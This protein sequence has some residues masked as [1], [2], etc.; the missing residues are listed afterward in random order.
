MAQEM[1]SDLR[2][3]RRCLLFDG[4][5]EAEL[6]SLAGL[7][8]E[9][10]FAPGTAIV[11]ENEPAN[12]I[13]IICDGLVDVV[14]R[15]PIGGREQRL[16]TLSA[17]NSFGEMAFVDGEPRSASVRAV[18]ATTVARL[19]MSRLRA[20]AS[21]EPGI[22]SGMLRNLAAYLAHRL[23]GTSEQTV[24]ALEQ[25]LAHERARVTM[26]KYVTYVIALMIAYAFMLRFAA[27]LAHNAASTSIVSIPVILGFAA[28]L[29]AMARHT[30]EPMSEY[31]LTL[32]GWRAS[33]SEALRWT[34]PV[35]TVLV[36]LK[37]TLVR[38]LPGLEG[39]P[40]F[41]FGGAFAPNATPE[42]L[43]FALMMNVA[44]IA[45]IPFQEFAARGALQGPLER[46]LTGKQAVPF[47]IVMAN[48]L[49]VT[50]HLHISTTFAAAAFPPGLLWGWLYSRN[51]N[52]LGPILSHVLIG[53]T[54]LYLLDFQRLLMR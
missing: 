32:H 50:S 53:G 45:M 39:E 38:L 19:S 3:L 22:E 13:F 46:F 1:T 43:H 54:G 20:L 37:W 29:F 48:G 33:V 11:R 10:R 23:R 40:V 18:E 35:L 49:F 41:S 7:L 34:I 24:R 30:G 28:G 4:F 6:E 36:L 2:V 25:E 12:D 21:K 5:S 15:A 44:Y 17:G 9:E 47:A 52:L 27:D 26:G 14:K 31:G 42:E 51:R 8:E 16:T